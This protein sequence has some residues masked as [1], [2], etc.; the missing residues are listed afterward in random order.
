MKSIRNQPAQV[1]G[2]DGVFRI[3]AADGFEQRWIALQNAGQV[4]IVPAI[5]NHLND[6][7]ARNTV[8]LHEVNQCFN[9]RI[10]RERVCSRGIGKLRVA[11]E[12]EDFRKGPLRVA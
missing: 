4:A 3:D 9:G 1:I 8:R 11:L 5:V 2:R 6:D 12:S 7:G 10:L